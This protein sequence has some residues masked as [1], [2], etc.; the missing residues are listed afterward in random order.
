[1]LMVGWLPYAIKNKS[2]KVLRTLFKNLQIA[3]NL[4]SQNIN[5]TSYENFKGTIVKCSQSLPANCK[6]AKCKFPEQ[7]KCSLLFFLNN[8]LRIFFEHY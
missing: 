7:A 6:F 5:K 1:M 3:Y 8:I 2:V 4:H